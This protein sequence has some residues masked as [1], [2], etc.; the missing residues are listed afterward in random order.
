M[1][2]TT[3]FNFFN[4]KK[5]GFKHFKFFFYFQKKILLGG[6]TDGVHVFCN[7]MTYI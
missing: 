1:D 4:I 3:F 6:Y 5:G 7:C 2:Y